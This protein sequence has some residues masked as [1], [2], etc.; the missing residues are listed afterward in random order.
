MRL[1]GLLGRPTTGGEFTMKAAA[2]TTTKKQLHVEIGEN[3]E[4]Q[5]ARNDISLT[6]LKRLCFTTR[7]YC[8]FLGINQSKCHIYPALQLCPLA[9]VWHVTYYI[10]NPEYTACL[11]HF[12]HSGRFRVESRWS[13]PGTGL[14]VLFW[15][16]CP[17][18]CCSVL[19]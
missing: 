13:S 7:V 4:K 9:Q 17:S 10:K 1:F 12:P 6:C 16:A 18:A 11:F 19:A 3:M 5:Q 2:T 15:C 8:L 14:T